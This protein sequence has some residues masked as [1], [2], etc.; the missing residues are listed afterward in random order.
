MDEPLGKVVEALL[1]KLSNF[2]CTGEVIEVF[3]WL[4]YFTFDAI[5]VFTV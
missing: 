4:H 2:A 1:K 5:G 3:D